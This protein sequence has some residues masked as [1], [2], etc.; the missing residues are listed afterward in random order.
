MAQENKQFLGTTVILPARDVKE[1]AQFYKKRL[2]FEID[3]RWEKPPYASVRH[4]KVVIE[5]GEGRK[6]YA[7][8]GVRCIHVTDV[9]GLYRELRAKKLE[10]VG[11]FA[12]RD[13]GSRDFR[14]KDNNGNL[15]IFGS[16]LPDKDQR[17]ANQN[18]A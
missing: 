2:G 15:L 1:T 17:F 11:D 6:Q 7:G 13:Y 14:V 3:L 12:D 9:D 10:F 5:F 18:V 4:G 8:S 16:P